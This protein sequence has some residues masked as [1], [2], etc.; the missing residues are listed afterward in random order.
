MVDRVRVGVVGTSGWTDLY[1]LSVIKSHPRAQLA[2][3][4]GRNTVRA[5]E[6]A[7]T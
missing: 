2:A 4:C 3:I 5:G 7:R 1:H 6:M